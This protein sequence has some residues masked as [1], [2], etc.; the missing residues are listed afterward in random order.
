[1]IDLASPMASDCATPTDPLAEEGSMSQ[2]SRWIPLA[3]VV[4]LVALFGCEK[5]TVEAPEERPEEFLEQVAEAFRGNQPV[6]I[7]HALPPSYQEDVRGLVETI[8]E[9]A[10]PAL[11]NRT[12]EVVAKLGRVLEEKK[13]LVLR[14]PILQ[15]PAVAQLPLAD[16]WDAVVRVLKAV[17][18]SDLAR[19]SNLATLDIEKLLAGPGAAA[20]ESLMTVWIPFQGE[21]AEKALRGLQN[22]KITRLN[23]DGDSALVKVESPGLPPEEYALAKV[24]GRWIPVQMRNTWPKNLAGARDSLGP[25]SVADTEV[26]EGLELLGKIEGHLD[27]MLAAQTNAEFSPHLTRLVEELQVLAPPPVEKTTPPMPIGN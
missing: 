9:R 6:I 3:Y 16:H 10:Q 2:Q 18:A 22:A 14:H 11:W 23:V 1:M 17:S 25:L 8:G 24:E 27:G 4:C 20:W 12:F 19:H 15:N 21:E 26:T 5:Q 7:W 13:E